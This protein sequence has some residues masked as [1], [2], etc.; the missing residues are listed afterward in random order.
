MTGATQD[1]SMSV[2]VE[3]MMKFAALG[4]TKKAMRRI[5]D[6]K[7]KP[8]GSH[9]TSPYTSRLRDNGGNHC[10]QVFV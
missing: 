1:A 3:D 10:I 9:T 6:V 4:C 2:G 5:C 8:G 7:G